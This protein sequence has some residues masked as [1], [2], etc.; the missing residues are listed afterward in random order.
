M[1][2]NKGINCGDG[3]DYFYAKHSFTGEE[4]ADIALINT[5]S[6]ESEDPKFRECKNE[7]ELIMYVKRNYPAPKFVGMVFSKSFFQTKEDK[8]SVKFVQA[9]RNT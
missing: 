9:L 7:H 1:D 3:I 2:G 5:N 6:K 4:Y 8:K